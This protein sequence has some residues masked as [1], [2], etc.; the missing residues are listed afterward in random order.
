MGEKYNRMMKLQFYRLNK[1]GETVTAAG[2]LFVDTG[3]KFTFHFDTPVKGAVLNDGNE[4]DLTKLEGHVREWWM[5]RDGIFLRVFIKINNKWHD[6]Q[7]NFY[8]AK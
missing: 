5:D 1:A 6:D 3:N 2:E 8:P 7:L 4:H